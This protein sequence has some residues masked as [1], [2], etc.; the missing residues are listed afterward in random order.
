MNKNTLLNGVTLLNTAVLIL[1]GVLYFTRD[2]R[3]VYV[4][5]AKLINE[6][7]GMADARKAYQQK[8]AGWKAN[9]DT[10]SNEVQKQIMEYEK[11]SARMTQK[12]KQLSQELIKTK[13][14]QLVQYQRAMNE[15]AQHED[16]KMTSDVVGQINLYLKKYGEE[17]GFT[18]IMAATEYGNVAYADPSLDIT[19]TVLEGLN[20]EYRGE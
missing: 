3:I 9:M 15:Q 18:I 20:R 11:E 2:N 17:K 12:E 19:G 1:I 5:S 8:A 10:L 7:I 4:D 13:Q 16:S 14:N 6:Y